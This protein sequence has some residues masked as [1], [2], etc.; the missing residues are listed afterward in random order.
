[1][2]AAGIQPFPGAVQT[3]PRVELEIAVQDTAGARTAMAAGANRLELCADLRVGGLTP[4]AGTVEAVLET[5]AGKSDAVHVLVRS[6]P[7]GFVY[8]S[9]EVDTMRRDIRALKAAG[10]H[11]VVVGALTPQG[12]ID[13][14][15]LEQWADAADGMHVTFHR[16]LD[17]CAD[18]LAQLAL[19]KGTGV[20]RVLSSGGAA[21]AIDGLDVLGRMVQQS[22]PGMAVMAGGGVRSADIAALIQAGVGSVHLSARTSR[23]DPHPAGP[24][25]GDQELD[26]TSGQLVAQARLEINRA[27][28]GTAM[29]QAG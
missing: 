21:R 10:A 29:A 24:G 9:D 1:M 28:A 13:V 14:P 15:A 26:A 17:A 2:T 23:L 25:G 6:R 18:P 19:L 4:S 5:L 7:G 12:T 11:G 16:A 8:S 22:S 20:G 27:W 3:P